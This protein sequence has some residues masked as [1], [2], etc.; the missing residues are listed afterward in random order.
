MQ[1]NEKKC[2]EMQRHIE[3]CR[4]FREMQR[5][6]ECTSTSTCTFAI[7]KYTQREALA[8]SGPPTANEKGERRR[9][10]ALPEILFLLFYLKEKN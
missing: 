5:S 6:S 3:K 7:N 8:E 9:G 2:R 1:R 4:E 10:I